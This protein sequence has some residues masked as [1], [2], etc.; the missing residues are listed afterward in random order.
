MTAAARTRTRL[1]NPRAAALPTGPLPRRRIAAGAALV[2]LGVAALGL[3]GR[4]ARDS[5]P[6]ALGSTSTLRGDPA[7]EVVIEGVRHPFRPLT[8]STNG[9]SDFVLAGPGENAAGQR[10]YVTVRAPGIVTVAFG[11]DSDTATPPKNQPDLRS[12]EVVHIQ[13]QAGA[14][15]TTVS[16][17][18]ANADPSRRLTAQ[19]RVRC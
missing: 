16:L 8:C 15:D 19:V 11:V 7:G 10:Y 5:T 12:A 17:V 1:P 3:W 14:V 2:G 9:A 6:A 13:P 4:A 18:D